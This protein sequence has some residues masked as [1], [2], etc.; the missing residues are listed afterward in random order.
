MSKSLKLEPNPA[1]KMAR[2]KAKS[3][4]VTVK[5]TIA[6]GIHKST[7]GSFPVPS[8]PTSPASKLHK[9]KQSV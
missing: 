2:D 9:N 4:L 3:D 8:S 1:F 6:M 7:V 5:Q